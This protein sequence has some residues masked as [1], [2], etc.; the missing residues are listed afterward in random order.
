MS[1]ATGR[2]KFGG[3][4]ALLSRFFGAPSTSSAKKKEPKS[5]EDDLMK[6]VQ[7]EDSMPSFLTRTANSPVKVYHVQRSR[8]EEIVVCVSFILLER[9]VGHPFRD[10]LL[11]RIL[12]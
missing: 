7:V 4:Q 9:L 12:S 1:K 11:G 2:S 5:N 3:E 10:R 8:K 6:D